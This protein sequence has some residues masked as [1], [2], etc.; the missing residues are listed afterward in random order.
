MHAYPNEEGISVYFRDITERRRL[1]EQVQQQA[2]KLELRVQERTAALA[3]ANAR[4]EQQAQQL[5][6][7][8][9]IDQ[10]ILSAGSTE[11]IARVAVDHVRQIV[12]CDWVTVLLFDARAIYS[13]LLTKNEDWPVDG[14]PADKIQLQGWRMA[15]DLLAGRNAEVED[16]RAL[17]DA[18]LAEIALLADG[19][20]S[21]SSVPLVVDGKTIGAIN[22]LRAQPGRLRPEHQEIARQ[23]ADSLAV[24][25]QNARLLEQVQG[26]RDQLQHLSRRLVE[27]QE[28]ERRTIA[29]ELHDEAGQSL[30]GLKLE[31]GF[32]AH[33]TQCPPPLAARIDELGRTV[34]DVM[35]GLHR[36]AVNLRPVSLDRL[37]LVAAASQLSATFERQTGLHVDLVVMGLEDPAEPDSYSQRLPALTETTIYRVIQEAMTNVARHAK[38]TR[39]GLILERDLERA[40]AI[41]EDDG[42]GFDV[43]AAMACGRLGLVGMRERTE[44]LG[45]KLTIESR[46][47]SGTTVYAEIPLAQAPE[48]A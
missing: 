30:T 5:R 17:A 37:G 11:T 27:A 45:G 39:V 7:L 25:F 44:M 41:I 34:D 9:E 24:A 15:P 42:A 35:V 22:L 40:L 23:V 32:V 46:P 31:L 3:A 33:D 2:E 19:V 38:A 4:L 6:A 26:S 10:V 36:L 47:G 43:D 13:R 18:S 29:R 48:P 1:Q 14:L 8:H 12:P 28:N 20:R 21:C 16:M